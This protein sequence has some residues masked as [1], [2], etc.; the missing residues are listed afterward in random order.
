M[1]SV[2]YAFMASVNSVNSKRPLLSSEI[3]TILCITI[4]I[5]HETGKQSVP[6]R[7]WERYVILAY[8][9]QDNELAE[10]AAGAGISDEEPLTSADFDNRVDFVRHASRPVA[11]NSA[12]GSCS[13]SLEQSINEL[14]LMRVELKGRGVVE[15]D[16]SDHGQRLLYLGDVH[17]DRTQRPYYRPQSYQQPLVADD[18]ARVR[19]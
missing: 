7:A 13:T 8:N 1:H 2:L 10:E 17:T 3:N 6:W 11:S 15:E 4:I 19:Y 14:Q 16:G 18:P 12:T 9:E 5:G